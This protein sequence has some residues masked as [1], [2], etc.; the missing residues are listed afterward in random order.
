MLS[1]AERNGTISA[2]VRSWRKYIQSDALINRYSV[3]WHFQEAHLQVSR[4]IY[5][6]ALVALQISTKLLE[7]RKQQAFFKSRYL[8]KTSCYPMTTKWLFLDLQITEWKKTVATMA[9]LSFHT[10]DIKSSFWNNWNRTPSVFFAYKI[11][12]S[13][14]SENPVRSRG[15][16]LTLTY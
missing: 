7:K 16:I 2:C 5:M 3:M 12:Y 13:K 9:A 8:C 10:V 6:L 1:L 14:P 15:D 11:F 4:V